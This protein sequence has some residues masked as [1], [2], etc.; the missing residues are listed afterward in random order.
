MSTTLF[1]MLICGLLVVSAICCTQQARALLR[2]DDVSLTNSVLF[3]V[4]S[5]AATA[6][7]GV[8][9]ILVAMAGVQ[10]FS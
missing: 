2:S 6:L 7:W 10:L 4:T 3:T 8:I 9:V 1:A 5:T